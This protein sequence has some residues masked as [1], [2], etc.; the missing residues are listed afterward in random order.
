MMQKEL[1]DITFVFILLLDSVLISIIRK[2]IAHQKKISNLNNL[3]YLI[4]AAWTRR[5]IS[6]NAKIHYI[7]TCT[8]LA[9]IVSFLKTNSVFS[10]FQIYKKLLHVKDRFT[11]SSEARQKKTESM[12]VLSLAEV[13]TTCKTSGRY[14]HKVSASVF[15]TS[16]RSSKS[17]LLPV[18]REAYRNWII[19]ICSTQRCHDIIV[20]MY[21]NVCNARAHTNY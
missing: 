4:R 12:F 18:K 9:I 20:T 10:I 8:N 2:E 21:G 7:L 6:T 11:L 19:I 5:Q 16:R 15:F 17:H 13:S 3:K 14:W 1:C